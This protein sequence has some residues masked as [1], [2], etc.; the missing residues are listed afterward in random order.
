VLSKV[1]LY[2]AELIAGIGEN[3]QDYFEGY[4]VSRKGSKVA[5]HRLGIMGLLCGGGFGII[6]Q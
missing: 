3:F 2:R 5:G 6:I 1:L 4:K